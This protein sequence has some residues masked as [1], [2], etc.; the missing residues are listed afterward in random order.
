[1]LKMFAL[2]ISY[3][4]RWVGEKSPVS[5]TEI[6]DESEGEQ[7]DGEKNNKVEEVEEDREMH[8]PAKNVHG[9]DDEDE[10]SQEKDDGSRSVQPEEIADAML[11][12]THPKG[13]DG[14]D[15]FETL[16]FGDVA[17]VESQWRLCVSP[18][19]VGEE[20]GE[21]EDNA[22]DREKIKEAWK[23]RSREKKEEKETEEKVG[24]KKKEEKETEK[25]VSKKEEKETEKKE[26]E[27]KEEP[28]QAKLKDMR[29]AV[30]TKRPLHEVTPGSQDTTK[31]NVVKVDSDEERDKTQAFKDPYHHTNHHH[32]YDILLTSSPSRVNLF[33]YETKLYLKYKCLF[34]SNLGVSEWIPSQLTCVRS[35]VWK[36]LVAKTCNTKQVH[37]SFS[38]WPGPTAFD[39]RTNAWR[40]DGAGC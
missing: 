17:A 3:L 35:S 37:D 34:K 28:S 23:Q 24:K 7:D 21:V 15:N 26:K 11:K 33:M 2:P 20:K 8:T 16:P 31:T 4:I 39:R 10:E 22:E 19:G 25:R 27:K 29:A 14:P 5:P 40:W 30:W 12:D 9:N 36:N 38:Y 1:M 6:E 32:N 18:E 13:E